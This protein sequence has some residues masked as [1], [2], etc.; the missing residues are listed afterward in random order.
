[1]SKPERIYTK[2]IPQSVVDYMMDAQRFYNFRERAMADDVFMG[3]ETNVDRLLKK[4]SIWKKLFA[5]IKY[6]FGFRII[7]KDT[8]REYQD[9][10]YW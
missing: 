5:K 10:D 2:D 1:M 6:P 8:I 4:T 7:H 9:E 3:M